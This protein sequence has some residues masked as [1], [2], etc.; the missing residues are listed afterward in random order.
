M[1]QHT[2]LKISVCQAPHHTPE[3]AGQD[4]LPMG[5]GHVKRRYPSGPGDPHGPQGLN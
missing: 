3:T 2:Q 4:P 1:I 5:S